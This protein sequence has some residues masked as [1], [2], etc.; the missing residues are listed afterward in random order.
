MKTHISHSD[1]VI[2]CP[3][4]AQI[5]TGKLDFMTSVTCEVCG[6]RVPLNERT[7][8]ADGVTQHETALQ[9]FAERDQGVSRM[10]RIAQ[11]VRDGHYREAL[12]AYSHVLHEEH[13]N[14]DAMYGMGYCLYKL[15]D[16]AEA[17]HYLQRAD[18]LGHPTA[19]QMVQRVDER[20]IERAGG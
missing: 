13:V 14:R 12:D 16:L 6:R 4:G 11:L 9:Y 1:G 8:H 18:A 5:R 19:H 15:G 17:R 20:L 2:Y 10:R 3:C 7:T